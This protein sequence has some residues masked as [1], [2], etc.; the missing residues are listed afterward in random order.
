MHTNPKNT[1]IILYDDYLELQL[2]QEHDTVWATQG[3]IV[4]LFDIDQS[5][6]AR[7]IKNIFATNE[8]DK[9]SN[10]Q[11]MHIA[12]SD[13]PVNLYSLDI[14]L[15]VGYRTNSGRATKFRR[16]ATGR[17]KEYLIQGYS[18][19]HK[20]LKE[21]QKTVELIH[22]QANNTGISLS[23]T[24]WLLDIISGYT[25]SFIL[26]NKFDSGRLEVAGNE[27]ITYVIQYNEAKEAIHKLKSTLT[28]KQEASELFGNEK[29]T[30]FIGIL[31]S[32]IQTF[33]GQYLYPTIE[34]QAA[35]LLYFIIKDHPF[36]DGN[37][38]IGA[39]LFMW[40]LEKNH[41]RFQSNGTPKINESGLVALTLLIASSPPS[42]KEI[43]I[44]LVINLIN[45]P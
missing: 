3:D 17:L 2:D 10:M 40:F 30:Q 16:W 23:E 5:V 37:K 45:T 29:D 42:E 7:H 11:K 15:A 1:S 32:V 8:V 24:K 25:K 28:K 36:S 20:R 27:N 31:Q 4:E 35:H 34:E 21:L 43:L 41:H 26:L 13:K 22:L 6:V 18:I 19:N 14:I 12:N 44:K 33:D 38:R 9:K 39:F